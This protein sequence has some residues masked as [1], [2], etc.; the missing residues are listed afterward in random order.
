M[1]KAT[2]VI[3][4]SPSDDI[5]ATLTK[6]VDAVNETNSKIDI[7][8]QRIEVMD[9]RLTDVESEI[10]GIKAT[11]ISHR[12]WPSPQQTTPTGGPVIEPVQ[13]W[14]RKPGY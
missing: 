13:S 5:S 12:Y 9:R 3:D 8:S 6:L 11:G 10:A 7:V 1:N 14:R 2:G 4:D